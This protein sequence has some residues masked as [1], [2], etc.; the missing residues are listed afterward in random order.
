ML[1]A[2]LS[3]LASVA[4]DVGAALVPRRLRAGV[5]MEELS[6]TSQ[7]FGS[8]AAIPVD[9]SCD[10]ADRSPQLTWSAP[11]EKTKAFAIVVE[12]PEAPG[13]DFTHWLVYD[14]PATTR[15]LAEGADIAAAGGAE[16]TS[17]FGRVGYGGPCPPRRE[18]HLYHFRVFALDA[19]LDPS[20]RAR[21]AMPSTRP[22][23]TTSSPPASSQGTF[24]R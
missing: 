17:S 22:W 21:L 24:S 14:V 6:V 12:D 4:P 20:S 8:G 3:S 9:N 13:G 16:G 11:P 2:V 10:G 7:S 23:P 5:T 18:L 19:P 15:T 1:G